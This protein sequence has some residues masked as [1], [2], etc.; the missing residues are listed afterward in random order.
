MIRLFGSM[1]AYVALGTML[2][3][4]AGMGYLWQAGKLDRQKTFKI[5]ALIHNVEFDPARA[6]ERKNQPEIDSS[7]LSFEDIERLRNVKSRD[8]ELKLQTLHQG[9]EQSNFERT[10]LSKDKERYLLLKNSFEQ[11]LEELQAE[12]EAKGYANVRLIWENI[13]PKKAKEQILKMVDADEMQDIVHILSEMPI[14]K[15]AKI[16]S[17]FATP[18]ETEILDKILRQIRQGGAIS[19]LVGDMRDAAK[20]Q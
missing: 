10:E 20:K 8:L 6:A 2:A 11:R 16:V 18:E 5:L 19:S 1:L 9:L 15:R 4:V 7:Q 12:T 17:Q 13:N 3:Q 14:G